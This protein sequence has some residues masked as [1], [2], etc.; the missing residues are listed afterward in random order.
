MTPTA[1]STPAPAGSRTA[2]PWLALVAPAVF[3]ACLAAALAS[4]GCSGVQASTYPGFRPGDFDSVAVKVEDGTGGRV[5]EELLRQIEDLFITELVGKGYATASRSD[6]SSL[7]EEDRLE[8][9]GITR[10]AGQ[11]YGRVLN[12]L[13]ILNVTVS[14]YD[15][16][17]QYGPPYMRD[18]V[19]VRDVMHLASD[20]CAI[21][22]RFIRRQD[23]AVMWS[24]AARN[25][26]GWN[27]E[28]APSDLLLASARAVSKEVPERQ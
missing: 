27:T 21:T 12:S 19:E 24:A 14:E 2:R 7:L 5:P 22:A 9:Q 4:A 13:L 16:E 6:V 17:D 15:Y 20:R 1:N 10:S 18:R 28:T 23:G 3:L 11:Q 25:G 8:A 26:S